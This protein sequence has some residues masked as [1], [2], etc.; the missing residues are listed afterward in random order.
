MLYFFGLQT[1]KQIL[2]WLQIKIF[3]SIMNNTCKSA[4]KYWPILVSMSKIS[5]NFLFHWRM[6]NIFKL[7][8]NQVWSSL[9]KF[10]QV[11]MDLIQKIKNIM[12]IFIVFV[13]WYLQLGPLAPLFRH[14]CIHYVRIFLDFFGPTHNKNISKNL[15]FFELT[16]PVLCCRNTHCRFSEFLFILFP[17]IFLVILLIKNFTTKFFSWNCNMQF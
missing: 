10:D 6:F 7:V 17:A 5:S 13:F 4:Q 2:V 3:L 9:I 11:W 14:H 1:N 12:A 15:S 16:H 8:R